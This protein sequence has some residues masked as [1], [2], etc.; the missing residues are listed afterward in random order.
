[1]T[2]SNK[3]MNEYHLTCF[4]LAHNKTVYTMVFHLTVLSDSLLL[5]IMQTILISSGIV[6]ILE[7][8]WKIQ[9]AKIHFR[10]HRLTNMK[11]ERH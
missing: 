7:L 1:M 4:Y 10:P 8:K 3:G 11:Q 9:R 6:G 2:L 5:W